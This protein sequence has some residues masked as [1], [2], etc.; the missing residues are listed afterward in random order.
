MD[1][2]VQEYA[3]LNLESWVLMNTFQTKM[4]HTIVGLSILALPISWIV[5][6]GVGSAYRAL[7]IMLYLLF[8]LIVIRSN[9]KINIYKETIALVSCWIVYT[10]LLYTSSARW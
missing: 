4:C 3:E 5:L 6:P 10:C 2:L 7:T 8:A 9:G 1:G